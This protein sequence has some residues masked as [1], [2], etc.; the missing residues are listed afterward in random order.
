MISDFSYEKK[1]SSVKN[2]LSKM[3]FEVALEEFAYKKKISNLFFIKLFFD[4]DDTRRR[5]GYV[6][7]S[8]WSTLRGSNNGFLIFDDLGRKIGIILESYDFCFKS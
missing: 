1:F 4:P 8:P 2:Q 7:A 5:P 6:K 3:R